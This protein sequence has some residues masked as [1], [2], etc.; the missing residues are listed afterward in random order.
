MPTTGKAIDDATE[1]LVDLA[2]FAFQ[3]APST[4]DPA[5]GC[6]AYH[7]AWSL[8]R[9]LESN[10]R[11][12]EG[13][14]FFTRELRKL[15]SS[16]GTVR[17]LVSGAADSGLPSHVARAYAG[18]GQKF[19]LVVVDRCRTPLAQIER[20]AASIGAEIE[21]TRA[22][23][24]QIDIEPVDAILAHS[25]LSFIPTKE[26]PA[27][28]AAWSRSLRQGGV[29]L[30]SQRMQPEDQ[31]YTPRNPAAHLAKRREDLIATLAKGN[32]FPLS[33]DQILQA[34]EGLWLNPMGGV[35][36][37]EQVIRQVGDAVGLRLESIDLDEGKTSLSPFV[38]KTDAV[39]RARAELVMRK[40]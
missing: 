10:A 12:P 1:D 29:V 30:M 4:C 26:L 15:A 2:G 18:T 31:P 24:D 35:P 32:P 33:Q 28:F 19:T 16:G 39:R 25:F 14:A 38:M 20:Y 11:P 34:A 9:Q 22:T 6:M 17:V 7:R 5:D 23:L 21:T 8:V 36:A 3:S 13:G 40:L 37:Y 27:L